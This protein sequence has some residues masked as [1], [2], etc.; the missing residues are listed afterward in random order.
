MAEKPEIGRDESLDALRGF[1]ILTMILSGRIPFGVLPGWMYHVQ[2]PPPS[3][4]FNPSIPGISWVDLVFP[5]FLFS[6]GA[7]FPFSLSKQLESGKKSRVYLSVVTRGL[8]LMAFAL[9]IY[10]I[11]PYALSANPGIEANILAISLFVLLFIIF[12]RFPASIPQGTVLPAKIAA[13][14]IL[15]TFLALYNFP[16]F[17]NFSFRKFDII[18]LVLSNVAVA[19]SFIWILTRES[20]LQKLFII[21]VL[22]GVRLSFSVEGSWIS[23][24]GKMW[25]GYLLFQLTF[26]KYLFIIIPGMI[27]GDVLFRY[28]KQSLD[29]NGSKSMYLLYSL[30][31]FGLTMIALIGL[32][33]RMISETVFVTLFV[34]LAMFIVLRNFSR[35][36][37]TRHYQLFL[38]GAAW[39]IIGLIFEPFEG[40]IK[41]DPSTMSY[42]FITS[43]LAIFM[44]EGFYLLFTRLNLKKY[45]SLLTDSGKNPMLAYAAGT[46]LLT[47]LAAITGLQELLVSLLPGPWPGVM[48]GVI[49]TLLLAVMVAFFTK[50]KLFWRT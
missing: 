22:L 20:I 33:N 4:T 34:L 36:T 27:A 25:P 46:N 40:G 11:R 8:L 26:L 44:L 32:Y 16:A 42:Y 31:C 28:K 41:K 23:D 10:H 12:L 38:W 48:R 15:I 14:G 37:D 45:F 50:K 47:P 7:A 17:G 24:A 49:L 1:A 13:S 9:I 21:G 18:I 2:V 29:N 39:L 3:H 6:M 35:Q 19:G 43:G 5:F 30:L